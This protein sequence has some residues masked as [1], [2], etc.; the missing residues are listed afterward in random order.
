MLLNPA[1]QL[2]HRAANHHDVPDMPPNRCR[3]DPNSG[4]L[5][6]TDLC[7]TV[8]Q[9]DGREHHECMASSQT[10]RHSESQRGHRR[11]VL[12]PSVLAGVAIEVASCSAHATPI[13]RYDELRFKLVVIRLAARR[14]GGRLPTDPAFF[15]HRVGTTDVSDLT[16]LH[17][18]R[19]RYKTRPA[20]AD[21]EH[22][23]ECQILSSGKR[24]SKSVWPRR[25]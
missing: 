9:C 15:S 16:T 24:A 11:R 25:E 22:G 12:A 19:T 7:G 20:E 17:A 14:G 13:L 21:I 5:R 23:A 3:V 2:L 8:H 18:T 6:V 1:P 10:A 4:C